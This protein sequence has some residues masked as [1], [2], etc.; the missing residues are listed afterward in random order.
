MANNK[1]IQFLRGTSAQRSSTS[2]ALMPGQP[3]IETDTGKLYVGTGA[4]TT[5][6]P[7]ATAKPISTNPDLQAF[8]EGVKAKTV[9]VK[10]G[11]R[12]F[13]EIEGKI[14]PAI[15]VNSTNDGTTW[16]VTLD[17]RYMIQPSGSTTVVWGNTAMFNYLNT[18]GTYSVTTTSGTSTASKNVKSVLER[19]PDY[20]RNNIV[21]ATKSGASSKLWL[22]AAEEI[23]GSCPSNFTADSSASQFE[24]YKQLIGTG[25][26][27]TSTNSALTSTYPSWLRTAS[28]SAKYWGLL[29]AN[30]FLSLINR[31]SAYCVV[32]CFNL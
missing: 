19:L 25:Q 32:F 26:S 5:T 15:C 6:T 29:I 14:F 21:A 27:P 16:Q 22:L 23:W 11:D 3:F 20:I 24:Y 13:I 12:S 9:A 4:G 8:W 30:G 2:E 10:A 31:A 1:S 17:E 18:A 7:L 28:S